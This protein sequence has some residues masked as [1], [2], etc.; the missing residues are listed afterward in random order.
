MGFFVKNKSF[1]S[2]TKKFPAKNIQ[3]WNSKP[4]TK[5]SNLEPSDIAHTPGGMNRADKSERR[6]L[7]YD[8]GLGSEASLETRVHR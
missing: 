1:C 3:P 6:G 8:R 5:I 4:F 2:K 7:L